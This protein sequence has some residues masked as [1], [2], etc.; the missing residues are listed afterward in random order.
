MLRKKH[1]RHMYQRRTELL[2][3]AS[4]LKRPCVISKRLPEVCLTSCAT[5][6]PSRVARFS[7]QIKSPRWRN[8]NQ[9]VSLP[10]WLAE[11]DVTHTWIL[12]CVSELGALQC[13]IVEQ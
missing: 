1:W 9:L 7:V 12:F 10:S 5:R 8:Q 4:K 3:I 13:R 11:L 2:T 6:Q